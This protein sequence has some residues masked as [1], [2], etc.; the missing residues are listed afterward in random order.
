MDGNF[1][2]YPNPSK[3]SDMRTLEDIIECHNKESK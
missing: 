2:K 3:S 1:R